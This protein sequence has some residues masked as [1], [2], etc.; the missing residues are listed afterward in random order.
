MSEVIEIKTGTDLSALELDRYCKEH[1]LTTKDLVFLGRE[2]KH[3]LF[4]MFDRDKA[5]MFKLRFCG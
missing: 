1:K 4:R 5:M 3:L 2:H